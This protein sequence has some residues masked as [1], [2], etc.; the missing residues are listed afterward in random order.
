[1]SEEK[2]MKK[3]FQTCFKDKSIHSKLFWFMSKWW[4]P[5]WSGSGVRFHLFLYS[6]SI[7][8]G[9][10]VIFPIR[11]FHRSFSIWH[12]K[13]VR[14]SFDR[15]A[16]R[17]TFVF[18]CHKQH[19]CQFIV[20]IYWITC[21]MVRS[22]LDISLMQT[23]VSCSSSTWNVE[24]YFCILFIYRNVL[25]RTHTYTLVFAI[26]KVSKWVHQMTQILRK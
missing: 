6:L 7:R 15:Y 9:R 2:K 5:I 14:F 23:L 17:Y 24:I 20:S 26:H 3:L 16:C 11:R 10:I 21:V 4:K 19:T 1:M 12:R 8:V 22:R 13:G 25:D 18:K